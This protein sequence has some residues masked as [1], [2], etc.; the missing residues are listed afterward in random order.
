M[1]RIMIAAILLAAPAAVSAQSAP[2][3]DL[4]ASTTATPAAPVADTATPAPRQHQVRVA[5]SPR[6]L[7]I[8]LARQANPEPVTTTKSGS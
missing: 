6:S 7:T 3:S 4:Q 2:A 1:K 5:Q 8:A